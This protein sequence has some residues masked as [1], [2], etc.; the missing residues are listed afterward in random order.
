MVYT[1][2][3]TAKTNGIEPHAYLLRILSLL[4]Y[5]DKSPLNAQ[6]DELQP[7]HPRMLESLLPA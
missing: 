6:L 5:L 4:P 3:E 1:L 7:W 2:V